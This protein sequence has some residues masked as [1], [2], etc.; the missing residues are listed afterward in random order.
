MTIY[1][2]KNKEA[3]STEI[4]N[5]IAV[6]DKDTWN[7]CKNIPFSWDIQ[8]GVFVDL[9]NTEKCRTELALKREQEFKSQFFKIDDYGYFRKQPKGY[10]SA[11]ESLNT[12]FIVVI[13][14]GVLPS[15]ILTF[16]KEPDFNKEEQ[17]TEKWLVANSFK[18]QQMTSEEFV[19]FHEAFVTAWNNE[20]H[21]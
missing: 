11:I 21:K 6:I 5:Y 9:R 4:K 17:C 8:D 18:N 10:G 14:K 7:A 15:N 2:D 13:G 3:Y 16:Y 1:F 12:A 19:K 20:E